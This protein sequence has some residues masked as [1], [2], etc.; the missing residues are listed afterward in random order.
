MILEQLQ[1]L[2]GRDFPVILAD[3]P[4]KFMTWS[5]RGQ[6]KGASQHYPTMS[7]EEICDLPVADVAAPDC[8]L[9]LWGCWPHLPDALEVIR[10]WGFTYCTCGFVWVKQNK[11][12][13]VLWADLEDLFLGLGYGTRGNTE[14]CLRARRGSPKKRD[15]AN[16]VPQLILSPV[17]E[18]SRKPDVQYER[19]EALYEGPYLEMFARTA[20]RGWTA[21]GDQV[22]RFA[23]TGPK[24]QEAGS[25]EPTP[26]VTAGGCNR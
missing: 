10:A 19:I 18:H 8:T 11:R 26:K 21:T 4:W 20:W 12:A 14:F 23:A 5:H 13:P 16:S 15:G 9:F 7:L 2:S 3:P 25:V 24:P 17:R 22:D 6:G 1:S